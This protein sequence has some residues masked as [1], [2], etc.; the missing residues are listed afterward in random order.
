MPR[1]WL[2][3]RLGVDR[4]GR[5]P[6]LRPCGARV[7][8]W[9]HRRWP[10]RLR[11]PCHH[12]KAVMRR[13]PYRRRCCLCHRLRR[14]R[15]PR[16]R[17]RSRRPTHSAS[18]A[19]AGTAVVLRRHRARRLLKPSSGLVATLASA[20]IARRLHLQVRNPRRAG[21][22]LAPVTKGAADVGLVVTTAPSHRRPLW[23]SWVPLVG[24]RV[25]RRRPRL[26]AAWRCH[27]LTP[28]RT[29]P[30]PR[31]V[32]CEHRRQARGG[33]SWPRSWNGR[34][35]SSGAQGRS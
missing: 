30:P 5:H 35:R 2:Q 18:A 34:R 11:P 32:Q 12:R 25:C 8:R 17:R 1:L 13:R 19:V 6:H 9:R 29:Q 3:T 31:R 27:H 28:T 33:R 20:G 24:S 4:P 16:R 15:F 26:A 21:R 22:R 23:R 7:L 14:A 10:H